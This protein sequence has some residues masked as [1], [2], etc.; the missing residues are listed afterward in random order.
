[1]HTVKPVLDGISRVQ[2]IFPLKSGFRLIKVYYDCHGTKF[3]LIKGPFKTGITVLYEDCCFPRCVSFQSGIYLQTFWKE[4]A[5]PS[6]KPEVG[7]RT[8]LRNVGSDIPDYIASHSI[9][10]QS[11]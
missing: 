7:G 9:R 1:M 10:Q 5:A 3:R 4:N 6:Y 2:N 11:S 8:F